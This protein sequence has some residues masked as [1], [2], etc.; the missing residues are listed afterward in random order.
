[1]NTERAGKQVKIT[2]SVQDLTNEPVIL[3]VS[4]QNP[5]CK[6]FIKKEI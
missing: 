3:Y 6:T 2:K 4:V 5:K 1:M